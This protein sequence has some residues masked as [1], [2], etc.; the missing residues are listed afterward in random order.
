MGT[1]SN[2]VYSLTNIINMYGLDGMAQPFLNMH[3]GKDTDAHLHP[4]LFPSSMGI[5]QPLLF[6]HLFPYTPVDPILPFIS[7]LGD[8]CWVML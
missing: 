1:V 6:S 5:A 3:I 7:I 4:P 8:I 2:I